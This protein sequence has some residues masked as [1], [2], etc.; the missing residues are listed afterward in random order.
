LRIIHLEED[1]T[2]GKMSHRRKNNLE[3]DRIA[4]KMS[5]AL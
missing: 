2:A 3:E 5:L 4:G 1:L